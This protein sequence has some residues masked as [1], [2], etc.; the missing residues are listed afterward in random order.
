MELAKQINS[1]DKTVRSKTVNDSKD[2]QSI[3]SNTS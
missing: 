1:N 2:Q 3:F